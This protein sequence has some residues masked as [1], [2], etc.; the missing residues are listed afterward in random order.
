M[1]KGKAEDNALVWLESKRVKEDGCQPS[2]ISVEA[3]KKPRGIHETYLLE[4]LWAGNPRALRALKDVVRLH[5][6]DV[7][8]LSETK[9][10][11]RRIDKLK[12]ALNYR[13]CF[14]VDS[15]GLSGGLCLF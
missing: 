9:A 13:N 2:K 4:I 1:G 14:S 10:G 3:A 11:K 5:H 12:G 15:K 7:L 8:F 6:P